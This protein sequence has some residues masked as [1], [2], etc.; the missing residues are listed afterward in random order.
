[1]FCLFQIWT[2]EAVED[3]KCQALAWRPPDGKV[4]AVGYDNGEI[5]LLDVEHNVPVMTNRING[6][7][8]SM[9]WST[10][11]HSEPFKKCHGGLNDSDGGGRLGKYFEI[12]C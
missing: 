5:A 8:T 1:M 3:V 10:C 7:I 4:L 6:A 2:T 12:F 9:R 11:E